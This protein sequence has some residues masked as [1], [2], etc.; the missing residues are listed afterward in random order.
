[1]FDYIVY[2]LYNVGFCISDMNI[3]VD[4]HHALSYRPAIL[5][6]LSNSFVIPFWNTSVRVTNN[7]HENEA[8]IIKFNQKLEY[9]V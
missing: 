1:M 2:F 3:H 7:A 8:R 4:K 5:Y 6:P 9:Q